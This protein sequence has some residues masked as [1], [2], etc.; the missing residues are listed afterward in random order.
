M[1][2]LNPRTEQIE[3]NVREQSLFNVD[4]VVTKQSAVE[5]AMRFNEVAGRLESRASVENYAAFG[6]A[7]AQSACG[8]GPVSWQPSPLRYL[9]Y[10]RLNIFRLFSS[11]NNPA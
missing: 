3:F 4:P 5:T 6:G 1:V 11:S 10:A 8:R 7:D 2:E 9:I